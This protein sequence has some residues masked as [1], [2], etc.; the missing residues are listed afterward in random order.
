MR[1][2][3]HR[4]GSMLSCPCITCFGRQYGIAARTPR[5]VAIYKSARLKPIEQASRRDW[6]SYFASVGT[7]WE[8]FCELVCY[9]VSQGLDASRYAPVA[10]LARAQPVVYLG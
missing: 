5:T 10:H 6:L 4:N 3:A 9:A 1:N 8:F 7:D 2:C